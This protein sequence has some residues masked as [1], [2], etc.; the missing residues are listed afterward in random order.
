MS[1]SCEPMDLESI[2]RL[3][4]AVLADGVCLLLRTD[5]ARVLQRELEWLLDE[6]GLDLFSFR[7]ICAV[8]GLEPVRVR[9]R[10]LSRRKF[11]TWMLA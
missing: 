8:L 11:P 1:A 5:Q 2:R 7:R 4:W 10:V 6:D 3:M 9:G